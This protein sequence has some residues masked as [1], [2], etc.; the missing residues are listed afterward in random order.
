GRPE[1][2][3]R[4][5]LVDHRAGPQEYLRNRGQERLSA[6]QALRMK[7][8]RVFGQSSLADTEQVFLAV[9]ACGRQSRGLARWPIGPALSTHKV[10]RRCG[11][12]TVLRFQSPLINPCMHF[13]RTRLSEIFHRIAIGAAVYHLTVPL[14]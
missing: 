14:S 4:R 11:P 1:T 7:L 13:S 6:L 8:N 5:H 10:C 2:G 3:H 9:V 12:E